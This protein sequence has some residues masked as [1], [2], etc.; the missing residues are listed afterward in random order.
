VAAAGDAEASYFT[1]D[2]QV[3][4]DPRLARPRAPSAFVMCPR[5]TEARARRIARSSSLTPGEF[6]L[7]VL[8]S[9][10]Q[11]HCLTSCFSNASMRASSSARI[12][13]PFG[14]DLDP[15][16]PRFDLTVELPSRGSEALDH[17]P[18][19]PRL[20]GA[21]ACAAPSARFVLKRGM[22]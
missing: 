11:P 17:E 22:M 20:A 15:L 7:D 19:R 13:R 1:F 5:D 6:R 3:V 18:G 12:L 16:Q 14:R 10:E 2:D 4:Y 8:H 21:S 9:L